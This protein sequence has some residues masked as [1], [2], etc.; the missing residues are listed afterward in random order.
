M[1]RFN[2]LGKFMATALSVAI[3]S[4]A[5]PPA[6]AALAGS[7]CLKV[8]AITLDGAKVLLCTKSGSKSVWKIASSA[9]LKSNKKKIDDLRLAVTGPLKTPAQELKPSSVEIKAKLLVEAQNRIDRLGD[10]IT[11][12]LL[13]S[14]TA[15]SLADSATVI[16]ENRLLRYEK[17]NSMLDVLLREA[18]NEDEKASILAQLAAMKHG[19]DLSKLEQI[20]AVEKAN[21]AIA[22][23]VTARGELSKA[24]AEAELAGFH[25]KYDFK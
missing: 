25:L 1:L 8:N 12:A 22:R 5:L 21:L 23:V 18:R 13:E 9:Q 20:V 4:V 3:C 10:E 24:L 15:V 17:F 14:E 2:V 11:K 7:K 6:N 16:F 19:F